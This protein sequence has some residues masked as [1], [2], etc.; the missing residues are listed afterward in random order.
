M[1]AF[2]LQMIKL[3]NAQELVWNSD[4]ICRMIKNLDASPDVDM[5][6][7]FIK[8]IEFLISLETGFFLHSVAYLAAE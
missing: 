4:V 6:V 2:A 3:M 7:Q 8:A 5:A 1:A